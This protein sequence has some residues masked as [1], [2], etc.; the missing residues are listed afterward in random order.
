VIAKTVGEQFAKDG[1]PA[2]YKI[3]AYTTVD[4]SLGYRLRNVSNVM[5][6][7]KVQVG[8]NNIFNKLDTTAISANSKGVAF[9]QYTFQAARSVTVSLTADF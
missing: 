7:A 8:I 3:D 4:A 1:E 2:A 5:R 6:N 9:D